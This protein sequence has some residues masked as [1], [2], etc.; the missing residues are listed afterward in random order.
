ML[1]RALTLAGSVA[2]FSFLGETATTT[3]AD[4]DFLSRSAKRSRAGLGLWGRV[5][6]RRGCNAF[7]G[8]GAD[9]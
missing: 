6:M 8:D 2:S 4:G 5:R 9:E 3:A 1:L 7:D